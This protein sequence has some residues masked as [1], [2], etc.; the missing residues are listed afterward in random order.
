MLTDRSL[1]I[2]TTA[3]GTHLTISFSHHIDPLQEG[4]MS[5]TFR[6]KT[7]YL[8]TFPKMPRFSTVK[9]SSWTLGRSCERVQSRVSFR[10][11][12]K[13]VGTL[14]RIPHFTPRKYRATQVFFP[15]SGSEDSRIFFVQVF[16]L[17][18]AVHQ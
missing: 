2:R 15:H 18:K 17:K 6:K 13:G 14:Q 12:G 11:Q 4:L 5:L 3:V 7:E 8:T 9:C 16:T 10:H 1:K